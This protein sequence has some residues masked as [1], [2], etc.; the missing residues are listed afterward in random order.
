MLKFGHPSNEVIDSAGASNALDYGILDISSWRLRHLMRLVDVTHSG[1]YGAQKMAMV[2]R[3]WEAQLSLLFNSRAEG[4][5]D[6]WAGFLEG[7]NRQSDSM[8]IGHQSAGYNVSAIFFLGDPVSYVTSQHIQRASFK[9][10]AP[11]A[12]AGNMETINDASGTDV[13]R[14]TA[15]LQ[16][17]SKLQG[18][19]GLGDLLTTRVF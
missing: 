6:N 18:W 3:H 5:E 14:F 7:D 9:Y 1:S 8:L 16:G 13:V 15:S 12:L 2:G 11:L 4:A 10:Y 17:N 19:V